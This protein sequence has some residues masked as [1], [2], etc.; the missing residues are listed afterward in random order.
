MF[1]EQRLRGEGADATGT[2]EF[3]EGDKQVHGEDQQFAH[4]RTLPLPP[5]DARLL[6]T[7]G[8]RHTTNSHP[9]GSVEGKIVLMSA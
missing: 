6:G 4:D 2:E 7:G 5:P 9:T 8:F 1:G 3:R